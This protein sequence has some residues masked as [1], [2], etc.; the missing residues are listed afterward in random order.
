MNLYLF[1]FRLTLFLAFFSFL[2]DSAFSQEP[3]SKKLIYYGWGIR[4]TQYVRENWK[5]M[6]EMP[7]DGTGI[8]VAIDQ[9]K[10]T[11]GNGATVNQL[12]WQVMGQR[13]FRIDDFRKAI[14]DLKIPRWQKFTDNFLPVALSSSISAARLNWFDDERWGIITNNFRVLSNIASEGGAKGLILDPE[15]YGYALFSYMSQQ[16][17]L[18]RPF[19]EY[20]EVAR[21]RGKEVMMAISTHLPRVVIFSLFGYTLPFSELKG[22]K[23]PKEIQYSLMPAFY[24]GLLEAMSDGACLIDGYEFAYGFK[25]RRQFLKGYQQIREEGFKISR[26]PDHY[27]KKVK[28]GFGLFLDYRNQHNYFSPEEFKKTLSAAL[29]VSDRY[30]WLYTQTPR[31]FPPSNVETHYVDAISE[32]R[33]S[34]KD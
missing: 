4:D 3:K 29:E 1:I 2:G 20:A 23:D 6:E 33:Q 13:S 18:D 26:M 5:Q 15:H 28:A 32:A 19:E 25:E 34:M 27:R 14:S 16:K 22:R 30:V 11:S 10:P 24:D 17:Q 31:F 9:S 8:M 7:F 12:G 21:R